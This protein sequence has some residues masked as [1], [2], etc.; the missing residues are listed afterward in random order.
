MDTKVNYRLALPACAIVLA[1]LSRLLPHPP[2]FTPMTALALFG[3]AS[4]SSRWLAFALPMAALLLSDVMLEITTRAGVLSGWLSRSYGFHRGMFVI[5]GIFVLIACIGFVLRKRRTVPAIV[6]VTLVSSLLFYLLANFSVWVVDG[7]Y[8]HTLEG[9]LQCYV[10]AI[11]FLKWNLLGNA[12]YVSILFGGLS[13][14]ERLIP[15]A[16]LNRPPAYA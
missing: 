16:V 12:F 1:A 11:P 8:P 3:A 10:A 2:N 7:M 14:L 4:I 13:S 9:L 6:A 5:Y 15:D